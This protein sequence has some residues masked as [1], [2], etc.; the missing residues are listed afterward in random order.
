MRKPS[1]PMGLDYVFLAISTSVLL[2]TP[3][4]SRAFSLE[5][6]DSYFASTQA[7]PLLTLQP[8][9][10]AGLAVNTLGSLQERL[11]DRNL[12]RHNDDIAST[13]SQYFPGIGQ[14][15]TATPLETRFTNTNANVQISPDLIVRESTDGNTHRAGFFVGHNRMQSGLDGMS[16]RGNDNKGAVSLE[17]QSLGVYW[18]MA[19]TQGWHLDAVAMGTRFDSIG[20]A[21]DG[22]RLDGNGHALTLSLEGGYP[23]TLSKNWVIEPQAQVI[24]QQFFPGAQDQAATLQAYDSMPT[25]TGRI[26]ARLSGRYRVSGMPLEPYVRTNVWHDFSGGDTLS[27]G[28]VDKISSGRNATTVELGLGLVARVNQKVSV[29]VS[30]DY[31]SNIDDDDLNGMI[32]N[33]GMRVRW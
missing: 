19:H 10:A 28:Q 8:P 23:I 20:R 33:I 4:E 7:M 5:D 32:G 12:E 14:A 26:G 27:L 6:D 11:A 2:A 15:R 31:S 1:N 3:V 30:A 21:D 9:T 18:T 24:N 16:P 22:S 25:W 29:F 13:W 17:G